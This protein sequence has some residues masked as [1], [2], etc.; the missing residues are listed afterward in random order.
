MEGSDVMLPC[1]MEGSDPNEYNTVSFNQITVLNALVGMGSLLVLA[2]LAPMNVYLCDAHMYTYLCSVMH[3]YVYIPLLCDAN[4]R[5]C[6]ST[7]S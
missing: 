5:C 7:P 6:R 2:P 1:D 4:T 3:T